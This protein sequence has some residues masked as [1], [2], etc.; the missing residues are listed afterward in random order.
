[1]RVLPNADAYYVI[2]DFVITSHV[3][4]IRLSN[5]TAQETHARLTII[6]TIAVLSIVLLDRFGLTLF[7]KIAAILVVAAIVWICLVA[8]GY[9]AGG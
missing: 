9:I 1:M 4:A 8:F 5:D 6:L 2:A 7:G 3:Y